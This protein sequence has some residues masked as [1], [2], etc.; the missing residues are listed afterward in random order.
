MPRSLPPAPLPPPPG[1]YR[2]LGL[3]NEEDDNLFEQLGI[4]RSAVQGVRDSKAP[5]A[6][7][8]EDDRAGDGKE[9]S[10]E[11]TMSSPAA[12]VAV[13]V[14]IVPP[15]SE[16][17]VEAPKE[18]GAS[19]DKPVSASAALTPGAEHAVSVDPS[20]ITVN[21][22]APEEDEKLA[23]AKAAKA[24]EAAAALQAAVASGDVT[25]PSGED[26]EVEVEAGA[27]ETGS[28]GSGGEGGGVPLGEESRD[29]LMTAAEEAAGEELVASLDVD[30]SPADVPAP[31]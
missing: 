20:A 9:V 6:G 31:S 15:G 1:L 11:V 22:V 28:S 24:A 8:G 30:E 23:S 18:A 12:A 27:G 17:A 4:S 21:V 3:E 29:S 26:K 19:D 5:N 7:T 14:G 13:A 2:V 25:Y 16:G 10:V